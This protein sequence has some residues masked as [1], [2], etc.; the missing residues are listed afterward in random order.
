MDL[1]HVTYLATNRSRKHTRLFASCTHEKPGPKAT[2]NVAFTD[3][4]CCHQLKQAFRSSVF[5][6]RINSQIK[7]RFERVIGE[8]PL[9]HTHAVLAAGCTGGQKRAR[10]NRWHPSS[11]CELPDLRNPCSEPLFIAQRRPLGGNDMV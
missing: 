6:E 1:D 2:P 8:E 5:D 11:G 10:D 7:G 3:V 9:E 4:A